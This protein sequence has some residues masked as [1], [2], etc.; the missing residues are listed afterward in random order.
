MKLESDSSFQLLSVFTQENKQHKSS[1]PICTDGKIEAQRFRNLSG[2]WQVSIPWF[3]WSRKWQP[4][5]VFLP[6]NFHGQRS[7]VGYSPWGCKE[8]GMTEHAH[9]HN[10][11]V[12][13]RRTHV[14]WNSGFASLPMDD[15]AK[16]FAWSESQFLLLQLWMIVYIWPDCDKQQM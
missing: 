11:M 6:G 10:S 8:L 5:L 9:T 2:V 16:E 13:L 14:G 1:F 7:L 15:C 12:R 3:P 4:A